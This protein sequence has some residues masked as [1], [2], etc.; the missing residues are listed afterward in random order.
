MPRISFVGQGG[1]L[2]FITDPALIYIDDIGVIAVNGRQ[3]IEGAG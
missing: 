3:K 1:K 2:F